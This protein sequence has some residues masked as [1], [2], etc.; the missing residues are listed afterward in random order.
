MRSAYVP[1]SAAFLLAPG[2]RILYEW[3][4]KDLKVPI[5]LNSSGHI[6]ANIAIVH[7]AITNGDIISPLLKMFPLA[8]EAKTPNF[9]SKM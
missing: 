9:S 3:V 8:A 4:R 5:I 2:T 6:G 1:G 7:K